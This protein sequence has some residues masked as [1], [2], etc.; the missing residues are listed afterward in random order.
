MKLEIYC[1]CGDGMKVEAPERVVQ[2][3]LEA[4]KSVHQ[5]RGHGECCAKV[6]RQARYE[7]DRKEA[8]RAERKRSERRNR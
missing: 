1:L 4:F 8:L 5:G 7:Q 2:T 6:A 3:A